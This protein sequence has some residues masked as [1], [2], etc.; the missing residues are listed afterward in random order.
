MYGKKG[1]SSFE[2]PKFVSPQETKNLV[3]TKNLD[4]LEIWSYE[5]I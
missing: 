3:V 4:I 1:R 2:L 5:N